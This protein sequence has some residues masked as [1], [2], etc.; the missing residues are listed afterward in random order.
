MGEKLRQLTNRRSSL[1][2]LQKAALHEGMITL[3]Q[4]AVDKMLRGMTTFEEVIRV[5][6]GER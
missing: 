1:A 6:L 5:T 3:Q 4:S 2:E